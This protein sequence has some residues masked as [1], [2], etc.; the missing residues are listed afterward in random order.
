MTPERLKLLQPN[1]L[2]PGPV[3]DEH[4]SIVH[5]GPPSE[6]AARVYIWQEMLHALID[7]ALQDPDQT[8]TAL[9]LGATSV[10]PGKVNL[11]LRGYSELAAYENLTEFC[12]ATNEYWPQLLN[13]IERRGDGLQIFGWVCMQTGDEGAL[14]RVHQVTHRSFFNY[15]HQVFLNIDPASRRVALYG[16]DENGRLVHI[17]FDLVRPRNAV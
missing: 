13:R 12:R 17:G 9:L 8:R 15:P 3:D 7:A 6:G 5:V 11:E 1:N 4:T 2:R 16:F 14:T 10:S